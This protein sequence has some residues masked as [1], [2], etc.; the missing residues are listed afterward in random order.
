MA[1]GWANKRR[2]RRPLPEVTALLVSSELLLFGPSAANSLQELRSL[3][4]QSS[5]QVGFKLK[6][7]SAEH[8]EAFGD[9]VAQE[10]P[11]VRQGVQSGLLLFFGAFE[12]QVNMGVTMVRGKIH[13]ADRDGADAGVRQLVTNQLLEL[14]AEAFCQPFIAVGVQK[15]R[16]TGPFAS[17]TSF[18]YSWVNG[19]NMAFCA[20]CGTEVQG[21]F[22]SKCGAGVA[23]A[24]AAAGPAQGGYQAPQQSYQAPQQAYQAPQAGYQ[25]PQPGYQPQPQGA[26]IGAQAS[27]LEENM[28]CALCYALTV[29]T[30][31]V[32]L[33]L[34]PYNQNKLIRFHAFQ[35]IFFWVAMMGA[36]IVAMI[37]SFILVFIP[38]LGHLLIL[39]IYIGLMIAGIGGW[40][41]LMYKAYNREKFVIPIIGPLAEKQA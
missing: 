18:K 8:A 32:F 13:V 9:L 25:A 29:L 39:L 22:C 4:S 12:G 20:N 1:Y 38:V 41:F 34:A 33:V 3:G 14:F 23:A 10:L 11:C 37:L 17:H 5:G 35:S 24:P 30:G 27:G 40:L 6:F 19:G 16:I 28:A 26:P 7:R 21:K 15:L 31:I 2:T 36:Y